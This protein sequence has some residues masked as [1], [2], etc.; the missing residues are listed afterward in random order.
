MKRS[1]VIMA[2]VALVAGMTNAT[3]TGTYV[4]VDP[5]AGTGNTT[6]ADSAAAW[7]DTTSDGTDGLWDY[8]PSTTP[9]SSGY[10]QGFN[11]ESWT[12]PPAGGTDPTIV[13]TISGLTVG[14]E[15]EIRVL[16]AAHYSAKWGVAASLNYPLDQWDAGVDDYDYDSPGDDTYIQHEFDASSVDTGIDMATNVDLDEVLIGTAVADAS[17]EIKVYVGAVDNIIDTKSYYRTWYD[18]VSYLA[19][20]EPATIGLLG[21]GLVG[22]LRKRK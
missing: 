3:I 17:G 8:L 10:L 19:V 16:F 7:Y 12:T 9:G 13:T 11:R 14:Q 1:L 6:N 21:L 2:V 5:T 22:L 20:P 4:P 15:Y 18:G